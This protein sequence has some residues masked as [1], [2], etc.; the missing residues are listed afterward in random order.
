MIGWWKKSNGYS[1]IGE[2]DGSRWGR[3]LVVVVVGAIVTS[4]VLLT[5]NP[6]QYRLYGVRLEEEC[7]EDCD[8]EAEAS[9]RAPSF[10][11]EAWEV[12]WTQGTEEESYIWTSTSANEDMLATVL[13]ATGVSATGIDIDANGTTL[14]FTGIGCVSK[15][16]TEGYGL[17]QIACVN[18]ASGE[19]RGLATFD[20]G[21]AIYWVDSSG[22]IYETAIHDSDGAYRTI[23]ALF[24]ELVDVAVDE[25]T[26]NLFVT[27]PYFLFKVDPATGEHTPVIRPPFK[28]LRGVAVDANSREVYF[29]ADS[30]I[31]KA[32]TSIVSGG[33]DDVVVVYDGLSSPYGVAVD[34]TQDLLVWATDAGIYRGSPNGDAEVVQVARV[35]DAKF[36]CVLAE[37]L[38]TP[39][40]TAVPTVGPTALPTGLPVPKPTSAP[41]SRPNPS[42]T[43]QPSAVPTTAPTRQPT[44]APTHLPSAFPSTR[45]APVPSSF[46]TDHPTGIPTS[47][48]TSLCF[49][50]MVDC[51]YC[52]LEGSECAQPITSC[53]YGTWPY[54]LVASCDVNFSGALVASPTDTRVCLADACYEASVA[55]CETSIEIF[56]ARTSKTGTNTLDFCTRNGSLYT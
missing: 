38:P 3:V 52:G 27:T 42:P 18:N 1:R 24:N 19:L 20:R 8:C 31:S 14:Y 6:R 7:E 35:D 46:P 44:P 17:E 45:P 40:P 9:T 50:Y 54:A 53:A 21:N 43:T 47:D 32:P 25:R 56:D 48:P 13:V 12:F 41:S 2:E 55:P 51:G 22:K 5:T 30:K 33:V 15:V 49:K 39:S 4:V 10:L 23:G 37:L 26:G 11:G 16:G 29:T 36:V 28:D 34:S